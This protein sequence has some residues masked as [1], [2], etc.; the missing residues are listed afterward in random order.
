MQTEEH[1]LLR[2]EFRTWITG[3]EVIASMFGL[4]ILGMAVMGGAGITWKTLPASSLEVG[5]QSR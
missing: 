5:A 4:V 1:D 2:P 3:T